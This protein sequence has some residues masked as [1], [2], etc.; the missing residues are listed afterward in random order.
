MLDRTVLL[1]APLLFALF[2]SLSVIDLGGASA[3]TPAAAE[4]AKHPCHAASSRDGDGDGAD[5]A[6]RGG[7]SRAGSVHA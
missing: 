4:L 6:A 3:G 1:L 5:E 2:L 7:A